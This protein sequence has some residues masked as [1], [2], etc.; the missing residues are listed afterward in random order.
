MRAKRSNC[1]EVIGGG[2][3]KGL[4]NHRE[5]EIVTEHRRLT[6]CRAGDIVPESEKEGLNFLFPGH[7]TSVDPL[8]E[9]LRRYGKS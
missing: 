5:S 9:A 8:L 7:L 1:D 6:A 3:M 2:S 4:T